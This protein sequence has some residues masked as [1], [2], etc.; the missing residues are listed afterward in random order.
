MRYAALLT[1]ELSHDFYDNKKS[2]DF[3]LVPSPECSKIITAHKMRW[4][5]MFSAWRLLA[6]VIAEDAKSV[7]VPVYKLA[8]PLEAGTTL[9]FYLQVVDPAALRFTKFH[10]GLDVGEALR[11]EIFA[12]YENK[13]HGSLDDSVFHHVQTDTFQVLQS[14]GEE[15]FR[16]KGHPIS[17]LERGEIQIEG[18]S[19]GYN[20]VRYEPGEKKVWIDTRE[21]ATAHEFRLSYYAVPDWAKGTFGLVDIL[22][23]E[24]LTLAQTYQLAL[25]SRS[26]KWKYYVA[27]NKPV[28]GIE[29]NAISSET[30]TFENPVEI[31]KN[32]PVGSFLLRKFPDAPI[33][34]LIESKSEVPF[35]ESVSKDLRLVQDGN[36]KTLRLPI[37]SRDQSEIQI[38]AHFS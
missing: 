25:A 28:T 10:A 34:T 30:L 24:P 23:Q 16:L 9:R 12:Y 20:I 18:Y 33:R 7:E 19:P 14:A 22:V 4:Q 29:D 3:R 1:I 5:E 32:D 31:P 36:T 13:E 38:I 11:G 27:T 15:V 17:R 37:P 8:Y 35:H 21:F 26:V 6:P 2:A